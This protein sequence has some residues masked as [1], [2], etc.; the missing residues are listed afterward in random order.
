MKI[1]LL[2]AA[3]SCKAGHRAFYISWFTICGV[4]WLAIHTCLFYG[5]LIHHEVKHEKEHADHND[6]ERKKEPITVITVLEKC[7][8]V[9]WYQY[10]KLFVM[11]YP[12]VG[13]ALHLAKINKHLEVEHKRAELRKEEKGEVPQPAVAPLD[14]EGL[15]CTNCT[16]QTVK[17]HPSLICNIFSKM[18]LMTAKYLAQLATVPLLTLQMFDSYALLCFAASDYCSNKSKYRFHV[19]QVAITF[20]FYCSLGLSL[21]TS[22]MLVWNP[23]PEV[24]KRDNT[25]TAS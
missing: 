13:E 2:K 21:L 20:A 9:V 7:R 4:I 1:L 16:L 5:L 8:E 14:L 18:F 11:G 23:W 3:P 25:D 6:Q 17:A 15:E 22:T 10:Y 24:V 19:V 12:N